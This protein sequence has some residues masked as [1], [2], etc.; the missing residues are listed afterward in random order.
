MN[1]EPVLHKPISPAPGSQWDIFDNQIPH[2]GRPHL[3]SNHD[4][5]H[6]MDSPQTDPGT[7]HA[8]SYGNDGQVGPGDLELSFLFLLPHSTRGAILTNPGYKPRAFSKGCSRFRIPLPLIP[9]LL[10][11]WFVLK[12][13]VF[14]F[15][16]WLRWGISSG[17][18]DTPDDECES[19]RCG[20]D[21]DFRQVGDPV[22]TSLLGTG[23]IQPLDASVI[24]GVWLLISSPRK[25]STRKVI[26]LDR[27]NGS[28]LVPPVG[29]GI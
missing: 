21:R 16:L 2:H 6:M 5:T 14:G 17:K 7:A 18:G 27:G 26:Q 3:Y 10:E 13:K 29:S 15:S 20:Y 12:A 11:G 23:A 28:I 22:R 9:S 8:L 19:A 25:P 1:G 4:F 24:F